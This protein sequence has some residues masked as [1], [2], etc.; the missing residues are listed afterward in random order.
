MTILSKM[1]FKFIGNIQ[2]YS[3]IYE[4][5][6]IRASLKRRTL[7]LLIFRAFRTVSIRRLEKV[8]VPKSKALSIYSS[9]YNIEILDP[10]H[11]ELS[12]HHFSA[13]W[14]F[15]VEDVI[16][17]PRQGLIYMLTG[18]F[19]IES[20]CWSP[21]EV[22]NSYPWIPR[23]TKSLPILSSGIPL[24]SSS[25]YHWLIEDLPCTL[26]AMKSDPSAPLIVSKKT[27]HYVREF[28]NNS[29][30]QLVYVD[31]P[32]KLEKIVFVEKCSDSGWPSH[33]DIS[34]LLDYPIFKKLLYRGIP[35]KKYYIS[36]RY[37]KRSPSNEVEIE[38]LA[39]DSGYEIL[40]LERMTH[41]KQIS[42]ISG[43]A[44]IVGVHGAGLA[45]MI[46]MK[47]GTK[48]VDIVNENYWTEATHRL[49]HIGNQ[50]YVPFIYQGSMNDPVNLKD[51]SFVLRK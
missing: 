46:W 26:F 18:E 1:Y 30:R 38:Q 28:A 5:N 11:N 34:E 22:F 41:A 14:C 27:P 39:V 13:R 2:F 49:S 37:S 6:R 9:A 17:E 31:G 45:N 21:I 19:L 23:K 40:Y 43:A 15:E 47:S 36:R 7:N 44:T 42:S 35:H 33:F 32:Q 10:R 4:P 29:G 12:G 3:L 16:L 51:L 48:I 50:E 20:S 24:T 25:Y 8:L